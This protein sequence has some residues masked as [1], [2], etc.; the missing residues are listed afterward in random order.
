VQVTDPNSRSL[1][2]DFPV[3]PANP[4]QDVLGVK[5]VHGDDLSRRLPIYAFGAALGGQRVLDAARIL[6]QQSGIRTAG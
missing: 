4:A 6:A 3:L 1:G 5:S 2:Q